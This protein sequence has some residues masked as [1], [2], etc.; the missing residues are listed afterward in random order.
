MPFIQPLRFILLILPLYGFG[1][2]Q[3]LYFVKKGRPAVVGTND[4]WPGENGAF[5][6]YRNSTY[7][8]VLRREGRRVVWVKDICDSAIYGV[9]NDYRWEIIRIELKQ[10]KKIIVFADSLP[11]GKVA[12]VLR[13]HFWG[14]ETGGWPKAFDR[15]MDSGKMERLAKVLAE[16]RAPVKR[17]IWVSPT[18]A[19]EVRGVNIGVVTA[20]IGGEYPLTIRGVNLNADLP[21]GILIPYAVIGIP[22]GWFDGLMGNK[23]DTATD[24][25]NIVYWGES[26]DT[27]GGVRGFSASL[28]GL[29]GVGVLKGA[30]VNGL[31]CM[32]TK[33]R[34]VA[35]AGALS[36]VNEF[37]GVVAAGLMNVTVIGKGLQM[38]VMNLAREGR[39]VQ[40]GLMNRCE[41]LK[42]IQIGLWNV[43]SKRRLPLI[44]WAF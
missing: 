44:N 9:T 22:F 28:G 13:N 21:G 43:N 39:G 20:N 29:I 14:F 27:L 18:T 35:I 6:L 1:Q 30:A 11:G 15:S 25:P 36:S 33:V 17:G 41:H 10:V 4:A 8:F 26:T 38:G 40:V 42:G 2:V 7:E 37:H 16:R 12:I 24:S 3:N 31:F 23:P 19:R 5:Y 34:G 32:V